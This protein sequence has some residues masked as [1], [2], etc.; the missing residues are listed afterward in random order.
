MTRN[1]FPSSAPNGPH[2]AEARSVRGVY[3]TGHQLWR[4]RCALPDASSRVMG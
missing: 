1:S 3:D 2:M 4:V